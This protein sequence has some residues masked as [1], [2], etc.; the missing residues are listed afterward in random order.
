MEALNHSLTSKPL[1]YKPLFLKPPLSHP[2]LFKATFSSRTSHSDCS[3]KKRSF[4]FTGITCRLKSPQDKKKNQ[5]SVTKKIILSDG[6]PPSLAEEGGGAARNEEVGGKP[7]SKN[8]VLSF[9]KRFPRKVLA[10][11]SNL[12][13]AIGEM[14]AVAALM[15]LGNVRLS[16][17]SNPL[18]F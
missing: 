14:F 9:A 17:N 8:G 1:F 16:Q 5:N 7:G 3:S 13:L 4:S 15:A 10:V 12:P 11:L 2:N 6:A 18:S